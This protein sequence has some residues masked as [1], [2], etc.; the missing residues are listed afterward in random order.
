MNE[1]REDQPRRCFGCRREIKNVLHTTD[2]VTFSGVPGYGS[3]F[4]GI[5]LCEQRLEIILCD[6][7]L[8]ERSDEIQIVNTPQPIKQE[9]TRTTWDPSRHCERYDGGE[10]DMGR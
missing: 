2:G 6:T 1:K 7:C 10:D 3:R 4:D 5:C 9:S 8:K